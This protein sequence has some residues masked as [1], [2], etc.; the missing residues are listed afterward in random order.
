[1]VL[2][3]RHEGG[4]GSVKWGALG[5]SRLKGLMYKELGLHGSLSELLGEFVS[6]YGEYHHTVAEICAGLPFSHNDGASEAPLQWKVL[7]LHYADIARRDERL[8]EICC[9]YMENCPSLLEHYRRER[10]L[11]RWCAESYG[12][13]CTTQRRC[14]KRWLNNN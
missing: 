2:A 11:P 9:Q 13:G 8:D 5:I 14:S 1:M 10:E 3:V 7:R 6:S 12:R 4:S